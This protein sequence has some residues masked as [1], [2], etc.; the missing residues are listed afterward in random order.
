MPRN[1]S[2]TTR[3]LQD[4]GSLKSR[5]AR[6]YG[7]GRINWDQFEYLGTRISEIE[8]ML[9]SIASNDPIRIKL[10]EARDTA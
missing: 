8:D 10:E 1:L 4:L 6:D 2:S 5:I 9:I 7:F 3:G